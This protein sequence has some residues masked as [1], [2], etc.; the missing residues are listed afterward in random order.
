MLYCNIVVRQF[1]PV[2]HYYIPFLTNNFGKGMNTLI[3]PAISLIVSLLSFYNDGFIYDFTK[4]DMPL[5]K[6]KKKTKPSQ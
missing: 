6:T 3:P 4:F 2:S 5:N 1:K